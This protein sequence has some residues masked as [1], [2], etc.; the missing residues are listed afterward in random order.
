[1]PSSITF[2]VFTVRIAD[3][4]MSGESLVDVFLAVPPEQAVRK[5]MEFSSED[6][7]SQFWVSVAR[8]LV[9]DTRLDPV[10]RRTAIEAI[11]RVGRKE[12]GKP[13]V[14]E[15]LKRLENDPETQRLAKARVHYS[16]VPTVIVTESLESPYLHSIKLDFMLQE[17]HFQDEAVAFLVEVRAEVCKDLRRK[18]FRSPVKYCE[19]VVR[20]ETYKH[21]ASAQLFQTASNLWRFTS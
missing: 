16:A 1:M 6:M 7:S 9:P 10:V 18:V 3:K 19:S 15:L 4:I 20:A 8:D 13:A 14:D 12:S 2:D 11:A 17:W 21:L 5:L